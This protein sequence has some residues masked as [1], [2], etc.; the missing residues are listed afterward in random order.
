MT[1]TLAAT[2]PPVDRV[3]FDLDLEAQCEAIW[4]ATLE[5]E[6]YE[7]SLRRHMPDV[8]IFDGDWNLH[9]ILGG[10]EYKATFSF[11]SNDSGPGQ[12]DI[13]FDSPV[14]QWIHDMDGRMNRGEK[15]NV[16]VAVEHCGARWSGRMD[17]CSVITNE[18]GDQILSVTWLHDYENLKWYTVWSNPFLPAAFQ[19]PR[20]F[21]L[22]GPVPWV[23][24]TTL[25][26]QLIR[27]HNALIT[28]PDDPL[29]FGSYL[30][31]FDQST[32]DVVVKPVTF[33]D[34]LAEGWVWGVVSSRWANWHDMAK[35]Q[36]EDGEF[37]VVVRRFFEGDPQ[38][39][40][41]ANLS[42][43]TL[44]VD[45]VDKSGR[46]VGTSHGGNIFDGL[47]VTAEEFADDFIDSTYEVIADVNLPEE[48]SLLGFKSTAREMPYVIFREGP[49]SAIQTSE[50]HVSPAKGVQ[51]NV[52]GHSMPGVN[53]AISASI[54]AAGDVLGGIVQIG[55]LGGSIDA[56]VKPLYEDTILAW[57]SV[58]STQRAQNSGRSRY[59]EYFQDGANKAYTIASLM[60]LR[61][62]FWATKTVIST[63]VSIVDGAPF[64]V[65]DNGV[66][67]FFLDDRV[68]IVLRNDTRKRIHMDRARRIDL[69]WSSDDPWPKWDIFIGDER[70]LQD[71]AQRAW[72]KIEA[73]VAA[74]RDLG[75]Y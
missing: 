42:H 32:W 36:L 2:Q 20:A 63:K 66:G 69:S 34:A 1:A 27:E 23:L 3:N 47:V 16:H 55:S 7:E 46:M 21:L 62:G 57:W 49:G 67:H 48:Y 72:A 71:P 9:H 65:G 35:S 61:A 8:M 25:H 38:P 33:L 58:K 73:I 15:R 59:F 52:G 68:G 56:L 75:V 70:A 26:L 30:D 19:F 29:D 22:A 39:W 18:D 44:W 28:I 6:R 11:V 12:T 10:A 5:Q 60:V 53:E 50:F 17:K 45:I 31:V 24:L 64:M 54:Q 40:D 51:V 14:A 43:G 74:L 37:S 13:P 41:G 4:G